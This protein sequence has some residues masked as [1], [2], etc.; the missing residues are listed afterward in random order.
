MNTTNTQHDND[1]IDML[2]E[3]L[4][5]LADMPST[6]PFPAGAHLVSLKAKRNSKK[7]GSYI[8]EMTFKAVVEL[9]DPSAAEPV[10]GDKS[11]MFISTKKKD[12]TANDFG[13]GQLKLF[14]KPIGAMLGTSSVTECLEATYDGID[15]IVVVGVKKGTDQYP[16]DQQTIIKAE[17]AE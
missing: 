4:D 13:Q 7:P 16:D 11:T 17:L 10:V 3:T 6:S 12:G 15:M 1:T 9:G 8:A 14:L 2:D 5:D